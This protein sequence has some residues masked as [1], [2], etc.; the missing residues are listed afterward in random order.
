MAHLQF[1]SILRHLRQLIG[2][3]PGADQTDGQLLFRFVHEHEEAAFT[4]L[5]QRH[6]PMVLGVCHRVLGNSAD[7][8]DAFQATFLV[9]TRKV[10]R[11]RQYGSLGNY[12]Y[13]VAHHTAL[14]ARAR[15]ARR[16][17][18]EREVGDIGPARH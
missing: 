11:L 9:L 3:S 7:A 8:E 1:A 2:Q 6:G 15:D 17:A 13:T 12:L 4:A 14:R 5:V 10:A 18:Q 16:R